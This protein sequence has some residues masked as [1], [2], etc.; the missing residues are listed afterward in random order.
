L[1]VDSAVLQD[2]QLRNLQLPIHDLYLV[3]IR[4][5]VMFNSSGI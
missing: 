5:Q 1:I 4:V 2:C 3:N